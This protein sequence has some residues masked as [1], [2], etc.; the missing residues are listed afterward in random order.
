M[1]IIKGVTACKVSECDSLQ[2]ELNLCS[3]GEWICDYHLDAEKRSFEGMAMN[4][5]ADIGLPQDEAESM[6]GD[7]QYQ[8]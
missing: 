4:A 1:E 6:L 3:G 5:M 7:Y 2:H 8:Y